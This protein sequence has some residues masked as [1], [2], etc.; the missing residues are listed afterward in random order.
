MELVYLKLL[1]QYDFLVE[2]QQ[3]AGILETDQVSKKMIC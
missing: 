1:Q 2:K 3:Q